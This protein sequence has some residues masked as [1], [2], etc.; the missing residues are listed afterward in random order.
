MPFRKSYGFCT[1]DQGET[2]A[3]GVRFGEFKQRLGKSLHSRVG[4]GRLVDNLPLQ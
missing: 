1:G 4:I 3:W 2:L